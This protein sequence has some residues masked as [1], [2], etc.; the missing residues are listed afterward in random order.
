MQNTTQQL[1]AVSRL[2]ADRSAIDTPRFRY[3]EDTIR[4]L[5]SL[6][7]EEVVASGGYDTYEALYDRLRLLSAISSQASVQ[8][9][10]KP[11]TQ[12]ALAQAKALREKTM[13]KMTQV[14]ASLQE[15]SAKVV[16]DKFVTCANAIAQAMAES[17]DISMSIYS[18]TIEDKQVHTAC[19]DRIGTPLR[20]SAQWVEGEVFH[21]RASYEKE[22]PARIYYD[23]G[24]TVS[25]TQE[26]IETTIKM[27]RDEGY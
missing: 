21:V 15:D 19:F 2:L 23:R 10:G 5:G 26:A 27:V 12:E 13:E 14:D 8:F 6:E 22:I 20:I 25:N 3:I 17:G 1:N 7:T 24:A 16:P 18:A 11:L 9:P 4:L